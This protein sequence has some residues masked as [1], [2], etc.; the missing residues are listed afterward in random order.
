[1]S[2]LSNFFLETVN[3]QSSPYNV[4]LNLDYLLRLFDWP[5][6]NPFFLLCYLSDSKGKQNFVN[7]IKIKKK[8][9]QQSLARL[10]NKAH[11]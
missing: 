5:Q 1:M 4:E 10:L 7:K 9:A 6:R 8:I 11:W 3:I 2:Y